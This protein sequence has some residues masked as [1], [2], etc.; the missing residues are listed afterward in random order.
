MAVE[1]PKHELV[2]DLRGAVDLLLGVVV[3]KLVV[4]LSHE[5]LARQDPACR[6]LPIHLRN[7]DPVVVGVELAEALLTGRFPLVVELFMD[8][9]S[10]VVEGL[11]NVELAQGR[12]ANHCLE[13]TEVLEV[14]GYD[15]RDPRILNLDRDWRPVGELCAIDL[16]NAGRR[17]RLVVEAAKH[18][19]GWL[20]DFVYEHV[21]HFSQRHDGRVR[22]KAGQDLLVGRSDVVWHPIVHIGDDLAGLHGQALHVA[23]DLDR[24]QRCLAVI[25]ELALA[26]AALFAGLCRASGEPQRQASA[27]SRREASELNGSPQA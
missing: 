24:V 10:N 15:L 11:A 23:Q 19:V 18:L 13:E 26:R 2:E 7:H 17:D 4:G 27:G 20:A 25:G 22:L 5:E 16:A 12:A 6:E 3:A 9:R 8:L 21:E 1:A 14:A